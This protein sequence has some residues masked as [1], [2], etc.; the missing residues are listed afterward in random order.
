MRKEAPNLK[1][2]KEGFGGWE[3][4]GDMMSLYYNLKKKR[5]GES[6][7]QSA[8]KPVGSGQASWSRPRCSELNSSTLL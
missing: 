4:K 1:E 6:R 3:G 5:K 8:K 2:S 7:G